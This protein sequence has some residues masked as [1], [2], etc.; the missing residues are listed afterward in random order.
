MLS[1]SYFDPYLITT[2]I[3][4]SSPKIIIGNPLTLPALNNTGIERIFHGEEEEG[5]GRRGGCGASML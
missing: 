4:I 3:I 2:E 1:R 5:G